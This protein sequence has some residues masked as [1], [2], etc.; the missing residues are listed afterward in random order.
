MIAAL[1]VACICSTIMYSRRRKFLSAAFAHRSAVRCGE[2][3]RCA[4]TTVQ[5]AGDC[6]VRN[7]LRALSRQMRAIHWLLRWP[8]PFL[9]RLGHK[10]VTADVPLYVAGLIG[11]GEQ[12]HS[13]IAIRLAKAT[14]WKQ[15]QIPF[16]W[17]HLRKSGA[18]GP[19]GGPT[20]T[21]V[22]GCGYRR[23]ARVG[24]GVRA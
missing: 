18:R 10:T 19:I 1:S 12:K 16:S 23:E 24:P 3:Q 14:M 6:F 20:R 13:T 21:H 11:P 2:R 4:G 7:S 8:K 22:P 15:H 5:A 17:C 9:D